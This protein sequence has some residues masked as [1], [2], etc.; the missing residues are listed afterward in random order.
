MTT[1]TLDQDLEQLTEQELRT[2]ILNLRNGIRL[3]RDEK[4][5]DRCWVDDLRLY[6]LLPEKLPAN[7]TLPEREEFLDNCQ[8]FY[9]S[10]RNSPKTFYK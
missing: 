4:G 10:R 8:R 3:H 5:H 1:T 7:T 2:E 9:E 6:E